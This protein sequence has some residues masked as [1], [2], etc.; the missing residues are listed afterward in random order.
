ML[1]RDEIDPEILVPQWDSKGTV[2]LKKATSKEEMPANPEQLRL[3]LT[4]MHN[5]LLMSSRLR[6]SSYSRS[7]KIVFVE[8]TATG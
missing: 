8:I 2:V 7:V 4:V 3:R 6:P 1:S 5:A